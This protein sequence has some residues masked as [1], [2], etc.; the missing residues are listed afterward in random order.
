LRIVTCPKPLRAIA[1]RNRW[2]LLCLLLALPGVALPGRAAAQGEPRTGTATAAPG[3]LAADLARWKRELVRLQTQGPPATSKEKRDVLSRLVTLGS[4]HLQGLNRRAE[5]PPPTATL[6]ASLQGP[7]PWPQ[8]DVDQLRDRRDG[9][10]SQLDSLARSLS[11]LDERV[12]ERT[13]ALQQAKQALRL[14]EDRQAGASGP[15]DE[16]RLR[17]AAELARLRARAAE[18]ELAITDAD[19]DFARG[20]HS[21]LQEA[22]QELDTQVAR[23]RSSQ[24]LDGEAL[25]SVVRESEAARAQVADERS[26]IA[27]RI[28]ATDPTDTGSRREQDVLRS[29]A[30]GLDELDE[31]YA[32]WPDAWKMRKSALEASG[33]SR[34]LQV[35]ELLSRAI[36]Q[37]QARERAA[38]DQIAFTR[39]AIR[40]QRARVAGLAPADVSRGPE[41]RLTQALEQDA[42]IRERIEEQLRRLSLL[43]ARS[44]DDL[45]LASA[46][47]PSE[48]LWARVRRA[49]VETAQRLWNYE[50][51]SVSDTVMTEG[52]SVTNVYGVTVQKSIGVLGL[53]ALG[54][55]MALLLT[56]RIIAALV[57]RGTVSAGLGRVLRRWVLSVSM[58]VVLVVVLRLVRIPL[59]VFAFLGGALAIG[60]GFG[61]QNIIKN[62]ISGAIMLFERKVRVGDLVGIAGVT[63]TVTS[64]DLRATTILGDNGIESMVPNSHVLENLVSNSTYRNPAVRRDVMV[65][66]AAGVD[67]VD[68]SDLIR[69]CALEHPRVLQE[70]APAVLLDA[71]SGDTQSFR[72]QYWFL[73]GKGE[74]GR[75]VDSDLRFAISEA[76]AKAGMPLS[77]PQLDVYLRQM[78]TAPAAPPI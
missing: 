60:V 62:L 30:Q 9:V 63:G 72:L 25:D 70:P 20:T 38:A 14:R 18:L 52:R 24:V 35:H 57:R 61:T 17:G 32:G 16:L 8:A 58:L 54:Y 44:R 33:E 66:V 29:M 21:W 26:R 77:Q 55:W 28:A 5:R 65:P 45:D 23:V 2:L 69:R 3:D 1:V 15:E 50:L 47:A 12:A 56:R 39:G 46:A 76:L 6:P 59:T 71:L 7:G 51:F 37:F 36:A 11:L 13:E 74:T 34:R 68:A 42:A 75:K 4:M 53:A 78:G 10:A 27:A 64:I 31:I 67:S 41:T 22:L 43:L 19:R 40:L 48:Y 73:V 49:V